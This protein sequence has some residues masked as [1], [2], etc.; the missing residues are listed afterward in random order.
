MRGDRYCQIC[1]KFLGNYM[2][3]DF[4]SLIR[5]KYCDECRPNAYADFEKIKHRRYRQRHQ[6]IKRL[7]KDQIAILKAENEALR[8]K[9]SELQSKK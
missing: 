1:G 5:K 4:Y 6:E 9:L 8:E 7:Q 2:L 3:D